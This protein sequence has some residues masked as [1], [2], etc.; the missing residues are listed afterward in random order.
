M[1]KKEQ[2]IQSI[3]ESL[4]GVQRATPGPFF[5]TRVMVQLSQERKSVWE[6]VSS[7]IARPAVAVSGLCL[8]LVVNM[9]VVVNQRT[10]L[11]ILSEN[12]EL[13][14]VDEYTIATASFYDYENM[15]KQ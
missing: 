3:L 2:K 10:R 5:F 15:E 11:P 9:L 12:A 13:T 4:D 6:R 7:L 1:S 8:I 14:M